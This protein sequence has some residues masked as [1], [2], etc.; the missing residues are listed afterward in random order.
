M[1]L[2]KTVWRL[3]AF[4]GSR[5]SAR[6]EQESRSWVVEGSPPVN[7]KCWK[8][9]W[10]EIMS[11]KTG[12]PTDPRV[13]YLCKAVIHRLNSPV[14]SL[15]VLGFRTPHA[16]YV[17]GF[18]PRSS[19]R[20]DRGL[21]TSLQCVS[22]SAEI[23]HLPYPRDHNGEWGAVCSRYFDAS[24]LGS[25]IPG[26]ICHLSLYSSK[27]TLQ[28]LPEQSPDQGAIIT[29]TMR[30]RW[31]R[32]GAK[33][34]DLSSGLPQERQPKISCTSSSCTKELFKFIQRAF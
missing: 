29:Y 7:T 14:A 8:M 15:P 25:G 22:E 6:E 12:R 23:W 10:C 19:V 26:Y 17:L 28:T 24:H 11:P 27:P 16:R 2:H 4:M 3:R 32:D 5:W 1:G 18:F 34:R 9:V 13:M 20:E 33:G 30:Q 31:A 21:C